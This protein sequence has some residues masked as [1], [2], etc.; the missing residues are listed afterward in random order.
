T[1]VADGAAPG[2]A[3]AANA[4][5]GVADSGPV[6]A[7]AAGDDFVPPSEDDIPDGPFGDVI[8]R[9]RDIFL[10]TPAN[11][12]EFVGNGLSCVNCHMGAGRVADAS[13]LWGAY[14][15]YPA[16]RA[17]NGRVNNFEERLQGCF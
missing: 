7:L 3:S 14:G 8:R 17:K 2:S 6:A 11:A 10:D 13:P 9:G 16:Y 12:G 5:A 1:G 4:E 15:R